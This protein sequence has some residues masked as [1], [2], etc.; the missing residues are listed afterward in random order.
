M[1][2]GIV[3][4]VGTPLEVYNNPVNMFVG[5]FLGSPS[6]NMVDS[7]V[8]SLDGAAVLQT[9]GGV[10]PV[11]REMISSDE[12]TVDRPLAIGIRPEDI[13]ITPGH[14]DGLNATIEVIESLGAA[15]VVYVRLGSQRIA[16]S[17]PP[18]FSAEFDAPI[19]LHLDMEKSHLF[20]PETEQVLNM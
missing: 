9:V 14:T 11:T 16:V 1:R 8:A 10:L 7:T 15:N 13:A 18:T 12:L 20:D 17:T 5:R 6:M 4:Q 3:Q 19:S 2:N